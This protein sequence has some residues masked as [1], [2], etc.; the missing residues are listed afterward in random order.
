M[1]AATAGVGGATVVATDVTRAHGTFVVLDGVSVVVGPRARIGV[2]GPNGVGK[3]TLLRVLAGV[4]EPDGGRVTLAPPTATV[5]YLPQEVDAVVGETLAAYLARRTG[6]AAADAELEAASA[7]LGSGEPGADDRY[8]T[9]L[10]R[11]L[12]LGGPDLEARAGAVCASLG[13]P[14]DRMDVAVADLSGGQAARA[15]LAAILLSRF[16]VLLLDE[17]TNDVDFAGLDRLERFVA[18]WS[19]ALVVVSHDRAFLEHTVDRVLELD[20]HTRRATEFGGG[21]TGYLEARAT[22]RRHA[23]EAYAEYRETRDDLRDRART[24]RK[25]AETGAR[26][27]KK[28]ATDHDKAQQSWRVNRTEKQAA[29]VRITEKALERLDVADKPWQGWDLHLELAPA[30]RS[31]DVVAR[32]VDA[33]VERG[34]FRLGPVSL[35][36]PWAERLAVTGPN[37]SGKTTLLRAILG[38]VP[39][40]AGERWLGP[41]VVVGELDQGRRTFAGDQS[42]LAAFEQASGLL[43]RDSRSLLAKFGLTA[44]HVGR[45]A[46]R[47]SPGERTRATLALLMAAGANCLILDEPTNHLDLAAIDQLEQALDGYD[48][49]LLVVTHDRR[50]LEAMRITSTIDLG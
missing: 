33:V 8:A 38:E 17:P 14:A 16:D 6:V 10:D 39:L 11:W 12:A 21:W 1:S 9:A 31:G 47:L 18:D 13:L 3:T 28:K 25:W 15:A 43:A 7:L 22:A 41:G 50:F 23:Q 36:I 19:G 26:A 5:G 20:E 4:E 29:K 44:D 30:A 24:Q 48:G 37:G 27:V 42:L 32:L 2:V 45:P 34:T 46:G 49:T 40:V 35:E